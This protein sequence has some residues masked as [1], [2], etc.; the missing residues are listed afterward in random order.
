M[1]LGRVPNEI[2][3]ALGHLIFLSTRE[4]FDKSLS[5]DTTQ[6]VADLAGRGFAIHQCK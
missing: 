6:I 5:I 4:L 2:L 1:A 3:Q